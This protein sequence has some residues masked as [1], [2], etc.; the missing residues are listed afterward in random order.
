VVGT[1]LAETSSKITGYVMG[2]VK[3]VIPASAQPGANRVFDRTTNAVES[4][5][6]WRETLTPP[7]RIRLHI[8]PF[9]DPRLY[10]LAGD[11]NVQAFKDLAGL[12]PN[13]SFLD[14]ACGCGRVARALTNYLDASATY[15]GFDA[16]KKPVEW[17]QSVITPRFPN[18][19]FR[20]ADT[21][22][23]RYN[24]LGRTGASEV[25]FPYEDNKFDFAFAGS[26]YTHM[27][28]EEVA[29]FVAE[30]K[31]VL[32]PGGTTLATYCL[33]NE[34]TLP[35]VVEGRSM[36]RLIYKY[37]DCMVRSPKDPAHFIAHP[38]S[39]VR[40][41]YAKVGLEI[42][43]PIERGTWAETTPDSV[44]LE[45][46]HLGGSPSQRASQDAVIAVKR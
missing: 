23:K 18:F 10:R 13:A 1:H 34:K 8:G 27:V 26:L 17:A 16:A 12:K 33:L 4:I 24:P 42:V 3:R 40:D 39:W 7:L 14:I 29:N 11:M 35:I 19:H 30:T 36:P 20:T 21:F 38:E 43:E 37:G 9:A 2:A 44:A 5:M 25:I 6:G 31:R 41:L 28:P 15:E 22:N 46:Y 45:K 32:K